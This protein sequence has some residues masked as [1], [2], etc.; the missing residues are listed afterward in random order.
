MAIQFTTTSQGNFKIT[1]EAEMFTSAQ[2]LA[3][4]EAIHHQYYTWFLSMAVMIHN[5]DESYGTRKGTR[6]NAAGTP[7]TAGTPG[8]RPRF[9]HRS[10]KARTRIP[11]V[12]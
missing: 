11:L 12:H 7:E 6:R 8:T 2:T 3:G 4:L 10:R 9:F 5:S 1:D